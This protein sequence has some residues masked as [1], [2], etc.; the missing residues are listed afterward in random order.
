MPSRKQQPVVALLIETS[1]S[2][3][4]DVCRGVA[5]NPVTARY[6]RLIAHPD[7]A[8]KAFAG[9]AEVTPIFADPADVRD[10]GIIPGFND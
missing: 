6:R 3:S 7:H 9:A 8:G 2:S 4:R 1:R 10:L 5:E